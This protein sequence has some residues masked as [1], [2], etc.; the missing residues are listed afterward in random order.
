M[1]GSVETFENKLAE[2]T[3]APYVVTTDCCTHAIELCFRL[4]KINS[5]RFPAHTYISVPMTM[6]LLD[7]DYTMTDQ[8]WEHEYQFMDTPVWDSARCLRP[9]MYREA[10]YQ[11]LSFGPGKPLN[12]VRGGAILLDDEANYE[13]LKAMSYDGREIKHKKWTEQST[14]T[15]GFHY[16]MRYEECDSA[17]TKLKEYQNNKRFQHSYQAYT[18]LRNYKIIK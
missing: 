7:V 2:F 12:N 11:C 3:G 16:M 9:N 8:E 15:Q 17:I 1:T 13:R 18:D 6:E 10:Q 5:C 4:L 14:F